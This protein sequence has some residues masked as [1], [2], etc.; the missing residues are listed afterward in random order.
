MERGVYLF[1]ALP[2]VRQLVNWLSIVLALRTKCINDVS[3]DR[4]KSRPNVSADKSE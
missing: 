2:E 1:T 4:Y 3:L